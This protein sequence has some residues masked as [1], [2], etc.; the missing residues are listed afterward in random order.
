MACHGAAGVSTMPGTPSLAGQPAYYVTAQLAQFVAGKRKSDVMEPM[1]KTIAAKDV[2]ELALAIEKLAP[3]PAPA[4]KDAARY[5]RGKTLA[6][7][8]HCDSCHQPDFSGIEAAPR[9]AHQREDYLVKALADFKRGS[10]IGYGEPVMPAVA[11]ALSDAEIADLAHY[12]SRF[13]QRP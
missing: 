5:A 13:T 4:E 3:P 2:R 10:R 7:R 6:A 12:L 11:A 8:E 9:L 1:A